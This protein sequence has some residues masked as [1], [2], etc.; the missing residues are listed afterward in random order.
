M[1]YQY[2]NCLGFEAPS[3]TWYAI[4]VPSIVLKNTKKEAEKQAG[5]FYRFVLS[6]VAGSDKPEPVL[7]AYT[8]SVISGNSEGISEL[9][10]DRAFVLTEKEFLELGGEIHEYVEEDTFDVLGSGEYP[11]YTYGDKCSLPWE[12]ICEGMKHEKLYYLDDEAYTINSLQE[13]SPE[14]E[15]AMRLS[16]EKLDGKSPSSTF[17]VRNG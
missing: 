3:G 12:K 11:L 9:L 14:Y 6:N 7:V 17:E 8:H 1:K 2:V 16:K 4:D 15:A 10:S 13:G 5:F